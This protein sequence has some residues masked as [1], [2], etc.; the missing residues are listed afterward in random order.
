MQK[1]SPVRIALLSAIAVAGIHLLTFPSFILDRLGV[2]PTGLTLR[3]AMPI[4]TIEGLGIAHY[5][6][7]IAALL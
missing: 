2:E 5:Q 4:H 1:F 6:Y 7:L 3:E